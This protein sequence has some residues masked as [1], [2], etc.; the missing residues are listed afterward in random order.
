MTDVLQALSDGTFRAR[1]LREVLRSSDLTEAVKV[2]L[3]AAG[4]EEMDA[5]GRFSVPRVDLAARIGRGPS[6]ITDRL[7]E[8][9]DRGFLVRVSAGRKGTTAVFAAA[10][11]G[12]AYADH[13]GDEDDPAKGPPIRTERKGPPTRTRTIFGSDLQVP[14]NPNGVRVGGPFSAIKGPPTRAT[15][16]EGG[17][18]VVKEVKEGADEGLF[19]VG[20]DAASRRAPHAPKEARRT[21]PKPAAAKTPIPDD[22]APTAE[23]RAWAKEK[24]PDVDVDL[25]TE[26]FVNHFLDRP[27]VRRPGWDRSWRNW[28]L[29]QQGWSAERAPRRTGAPA[30]GH[31]PYRNP[32]D[33]SVYDQDL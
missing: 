11:E 33:P 21:G 13:F 32:T 15:N 17:E 8:A 6:R 18:G 9:V 7:G 10:L 22:F 31:Q 23:M 2:L 25:Q 5:A 24:C 30:T 27:A 3:I 1:W 12:S 4:L 28:M 16:R 19:D 26:I 29:R 20:E 14:K